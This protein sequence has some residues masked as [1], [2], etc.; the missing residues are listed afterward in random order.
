[1]TKTL[2]ILIGLLL[3]YGPNINAQSKINT[4]SSNFKIYNIGNYQIKYAKGAKLD[5]GQAY[6]LIEKSEKSNV[7]DW[8][9]PTVEELKEIY[10]DRQ[11]IGIS[12][13][14][15]WSATLSGPLR[16]GFI[17]CIDFAKGE[18]FILNEGKCFYLLVK[19]GK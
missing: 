10:F 1:M 5:W 9:L 2:S 3:C 11:S 12:S 15:F 13:G 14:T 19:H 6:D 18:E 16:M 8:R 7:N 17:N 4:S